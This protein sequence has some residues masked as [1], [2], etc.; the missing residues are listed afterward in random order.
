V[1]AAEPFPADDVALV[2]MGLEPGLVDEA[3][4]EAIAEA[5]R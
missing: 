1:V 2:G 3:A 4:V 5:G